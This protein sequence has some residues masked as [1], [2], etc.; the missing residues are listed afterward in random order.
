M[1]EIQ[2]EMPG[3]RSRPGKS[4]ES[5]SPRAR[6]T[7]A[8]E[9]YETSGRSFIVLVFLICVII[10]AFFYVGPVRLTFLR[11]FLLLAFTPLFL[12]WLTGAYNGIR[13]P[14][15]CSQCP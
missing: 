6:L 9:T 4:D 8:A 7:R 2:S 14:K 3:R 10:P 5:Q 13:L 1:T 15:P 12:R 11:V